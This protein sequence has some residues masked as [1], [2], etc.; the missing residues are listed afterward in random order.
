MGGGGGGGWG[1]GGGGGGGGG[2]VAYP[3]LHGLGC[4]AARWQLGAGID[5]LFGAF[6]RLF[7][8]Y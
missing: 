1:G 3:S 7:N 8:Y 5:L 4:S 2:L 6:C